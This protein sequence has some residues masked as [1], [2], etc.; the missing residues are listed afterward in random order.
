MIAS[1]LEKLKV[2]CERLEMWLR[3]KMLSNFG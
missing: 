2:G 3:A 1:A